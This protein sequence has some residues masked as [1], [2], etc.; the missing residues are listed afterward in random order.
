MISTCRGVRLNSLNMLRVR[1]YGRGSWSCRPQLYAICRQAQKSGGE[2]V[3]IPAQ[4]GRQPAEHAKP[5]LARLA[6]EPLRRHFGD[7]P[8]Q[9]VAFHQKLDAVT[10]A[11]VGL[12]YDASDQ[13]PREQA[14]AV[15]GVMRRQPGEMI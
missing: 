4:I 14:K 10:E 7:R 12:D 9:P 3:K 8:A 1:L 15:A 5:A 2:G 11:A 13:P 6:L